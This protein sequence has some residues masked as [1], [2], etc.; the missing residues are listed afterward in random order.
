MVKSG[1]GLFA[2]RRKSQ[3]NAID[4]AEPFPTHDVAPRPDSGSGGGFRIM[5]AAEA[6]VRKKEEK[7][8]AEEKTGS[9]FR[10]SGF[11]SKGRN[12]SFEDE[13]PGSSKRYVQSWPP[14]CLG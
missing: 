3:G 11:G 2:G 4:E 7:R 9:K 5:T 13:S 1:L 14:P 12:H 8:R 6:E 10:F